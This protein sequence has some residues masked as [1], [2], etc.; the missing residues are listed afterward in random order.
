MI[1]AMA[2]VWL[3]KLL[4]FQFFIFVM[5]SVAQ[6]ILIGIVTPFKTRHENNLETANEVLTMLIMYHI[7]CFTDFVPEEK[8]RYYIGY[9]C[10]AANIAHLAFNMYHI[11]RI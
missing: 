6:I 8:T 3:R 1:L 4:V 7:F 11:L 5:C 9:T 2:V 10:L